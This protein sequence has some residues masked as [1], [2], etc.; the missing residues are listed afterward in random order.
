MPGASLMAC[1]DRLS[2]PQ[3]GQNINVS[4][5]GIAKLIGMMLEEDDD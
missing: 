4:V 1:Y 2:P 5:N 3:T